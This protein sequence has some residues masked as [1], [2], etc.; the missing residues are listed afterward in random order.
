MQYFSNNKSTHDLSGILSTSPRMIK[1]N[2]FVEA[3]LLLQEQRKAADEL[4]VDLEHEHDMERKHVQDRLLA[5]KKGI[6]TT[7]GRGNTNIGNTSMGSVAADSHEVDDE[8][9]VNL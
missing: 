5:K 7:V 9:D 8:I 2:T 6:P 3:Q 1:G 4:N